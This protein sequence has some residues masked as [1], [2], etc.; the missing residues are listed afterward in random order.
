MKMTLKEFTKELNGKNNRVEGELIRTILYSLLVSFGL[1]AILYFVKLRYVEDFL[2]K[3]GF[4]IFFAILS[5]AIILPSI[6]QIRAYK[7]LA[8]MSGMMV[9]MTTGMIA[10]F[11]PGFFIGSTSGMF[12]GSVFG[13]GIGIFMGIWN[14]KCCGVMGIIE[15]LMAGFMGALMG[16]MTAVMM[17]NDNL[18]AAGVIVFL[19]SSVIVFSL[20][21]MIYKETKE[22]E[23]QVK[24]DYSLVIFLSIILTGLTIWFM[25]FGPR[26]VLFG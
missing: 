22:S 7:N 18:R 21:F 11:L 8:C 13:M 19:I 25:V 9:G 12:W 3:Y 23:R 24:E 17:I 10:G 16:A 4:F 26:S 20:N 1:F 14:G 6:R 15:G 5:Y 2:P